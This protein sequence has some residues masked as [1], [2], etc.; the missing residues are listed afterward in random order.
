MLTRAPIGPQRATLATACRSASPAPSWPPARP[1]CWRRCWS[2]CARRA[3]RCESDDGGTR[4]SPRRCSGRGCGRSSCCRC[5]CW[6]RWSPPSPV[7]ADAA[8]SPPTSSD[9]E[10]SA[11]IHLGLPDAPGRVLAGAGIYGVLARRNAVL[12]LIGVELILNAANLLLRRGRRR[13]GATR[14]AAGHVARRCSSSPSPPPR[15]AS[16]SPSCWRCSAAAATSTSPSAAAERARCTASARLAVLLPAVDGSVLALAAG[17]SAAAGPL[18]C[19]SGRRV[20]PAGRRAA[21]AR[22]RAARCCSAPA[23]PAVGVV[24]TVPPLPL[25]R[26]RRAAAPASPTPC[27]RSSPSS[28]AMVGLGG[29]GVRRWY[30]RDDPRY[31]VFAATVSLFLAAMLLV[32]QSGDLVL[33]P[34]R[35]GGHG[36]VLLPAHRPRQRP[37]AARRAAVKAFLVTRVADIGLRRRPGDPRRRGRHAPTSAVIAHWTAAVRRRIAAS[38]PAAAADRR[39]AAAA[40]GVAGKSGPVPFHDWLPDAMEGPTPASA[41]IH[42]ATM[43]AAGT[44]VL[45]RL[46][47]S[48]RPPTPRAVVLGVLAALTM[49]WAAAARLRPERPQADARLLHPQPDRR[50]GSARS[51][52]CWADEA[53][54]WR[55]ATCSPTRC[56]RRCSS[57]RSGW[58]RPRRRHRV[59]ALRG[60]LGAAAASPYWSLAVGLASLAGVPPLVGFFSKECVLV[61]AEEAPTRPRR[62]AWPGSSSSRWSSPSALTAAYCM[63]AWLLTCSRREAAEIERRTRPSSGPS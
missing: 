48:S 52:S 41:L 33:H 9:R 16:R 53:P 13:V 58:L 25:G 55:S 21:A 39:A 28:V 38:S 49:V 15:S 56:S 19:A 10:G 61:A 7:V 22:P 42:A 8:W 43:V 30:L 37:E 60:G 45:A 63:R 32:V 51:P 46:S 50:H 29:P 26:A 5:C 47:R 35:L 59:V 17:R 2:R 54:A 24:P 11:L 31:A 14:C 27:R 23:R 44:Y 62:A 1:R 4:A 12:V 36:L 3:G 57:S 6:W 18:A 34:G 20:L 40:A